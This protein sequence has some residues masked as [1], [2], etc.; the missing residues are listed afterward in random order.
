MPVLLGQCLV[1]CTSILRSCHLRRL[2]VVISVGRSQA[3]Y[4]WDFWRGKPLFP[5]VLVRT[6]T[7]QDLLS[8]SSLKSLSVSKLPLLVDQPGDLVRMRKRSF[9]PRPKITVIGLGA[10]LVHTRVDQYRAFSARD[11]N[12]VY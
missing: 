4:A 3:L 5:S 11:H 8:A 6:Q 2:S 7:T 1:Q 12:S 9:V 10:R